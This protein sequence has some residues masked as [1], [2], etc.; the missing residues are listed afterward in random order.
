[1]R[2]EYLL[3]DNDN[4]IMDFAAAEA[5]ALRETLAAAGLP[6]DAET[7]AAYERINTALWKALERGETT[8]PKLKVERFRQLLAHLGVEGDPAAL[9]AAYASNLGNHADLLPG[10]E[11]FIRA[12]HGRMKIALVSNGVSAIQ[13]SRLALCPLTPLFDA[14][15]I[16]EECG[17]AKPD[18]RLLEIAIEKLGCTDK[19]RAVMMGD[20]LSAD[21][22]AANNAG[23]DSIF[24]SLKGTPSDKA[25]V[26]VYTHEEALRWLTGDGPDVPAD[27]SDRMPKGMAPW[28]KVRC[29]R[30]CFHD[31]L[32]AAGFCCM[33]DQEQPTAEDRAPALLAMTRYAR[34]KNG[35]LQLVE[36]ELRQLDADKGTIYRNGYPVGSILV[37]Q[38]AMTDDLPRWD[39]ALYQMLGRAQQA[40]VGFRFPGMEPDYCNA[41]LCMYV[42]DFPMAMRLEAEL[43]F[44]RTLPLLDMLASPAAHAAYW[45]KRLAGLPDRH[46]SDYGRALWPVLREGDWALAEQF[47][48]RSY[49]RDEMRVRLADVIA[50]RDQQAA[51]QLL[52]ENRRAN[53][54]L[55]A[56]EVP[57]LRLC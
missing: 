52:A 50:R 39:H 1:M 13:R 40:L 25:T 54:A 28:R 30:E 43:F 51:D 34:V 31:G 24:F 48:Q 42:D 45:R 22:A 55:L 12:V 41:F 21:I 37:Q 2:Y 20:S 3:I 26:T 36:C 53:E 38:Y 4:T 19:S 57:G 15:V 14:I 35:M 17:V 23:M 18:P 47:L 5:K 27:W 9:G 33:S 11:E 46:P 8:Q 56:A 6:T 44:T 16:S 7:L 32:T 49:Y 10:A 29:F